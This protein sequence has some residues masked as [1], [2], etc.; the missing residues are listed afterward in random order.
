[1]NMSDKK[2]TKEE[3]DKL[4]DQLGQNRKFTEPTDQNFDDFN[5]WNVSTKKASFKRIIG[6]SLTEEFSE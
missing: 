6:S 4:L 2:L 5:P 3:I 1:M